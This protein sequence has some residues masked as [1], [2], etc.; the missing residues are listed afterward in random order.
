MT[1]KQEKIQLLPPD[2]KDENPIDLT[3]DIVSLIRDF[4]DPDSEVL[5]TTRCLGIPSPKQK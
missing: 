1:E 4:D 3:T 2:T 5:P